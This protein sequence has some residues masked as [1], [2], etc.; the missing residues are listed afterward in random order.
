MWKSLSLLAFLA[1]LPTTGF[2]QTP[3]QPDF[4]KLTL[5]ELLDVN[6]TSVSRRDEPLGQTAAAITVIT[7]EDIRRTGVTSIPE[8]LRLVPGMQ[9]ARI[10][11]SSWAISA[12]GF[13][14][15]LSD[16]MLVLI[17]GR[18]VYSPIFAGVFWELQDLV[19][20]DVDR[21]EVVRGPGGTLWGANAVNGVVSI[22]TKSAHRTRSTTII[23]TG[24]GAES[25][26]SASFREGAAISPD[27]S[28][29]VYG[30]YSYR[31]QL[32][33]P[34]G[35]PSQDSA[36]FGRVGFRVDSS[37]GQNEFTLQADAFRGLE[38]L[39]G[40]PDAK[41]LGGDLLGRWSRRI[42]NDSSIQVKAS[43]DRLLRRALPNSDIH[44]KIFD[45]ELQ[46]DFA[47]GVHQITWGAGYRWNNDTAF[48]MPSLQFIPVSRTYP[49]GTAFIQ[50]EILL[51]QDRLRLQFGSKFEHNDFSGFEVQPSIRASWTIRPEAFMWVA[52]S[53]ALRTPTRFDT[54]SNIPEGAV[55]L[56]GNKDF[57]SEDVVA[58]ES[59]YRSQIA[60]RISADFAAFFN[61]YDDLRTIELV[62]GPR[63]AVSFL[64]NL[65]A[66]TYGGEVSVN[67]DAT[68]S[69]RFSS[70][71]AY[72]G[73][74]LR[75]D[76]GHID[77]AGNSLEGN[78]PKHQ[79]FIR[80]AVDIS[81]RIEWDSTLR[82]VSRLPSPATPKYFEFDARIGWN[83]MATVEL[84]AIGRNLLHKR[85]TEF[86]QT[87]TIQAQRDVYGRVAI[88]F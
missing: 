73:K 62:P 27:T 50:D 49:L 34:N 5:E 64:N 37:K 57:K 41:L 45:I 6:V 2:S 19:L 70:G 67:F 47:A 69:L 84:S 80:A 75:M 35:T 12:R 85:H 38:G 60:R 9:V 23:A 22:I 25:L 14:S 59:G 32:V 77:F 13:N 42:A 11:A 72:L 55:T 78:D 51:A 31:D 48:P 18:T 68:E 53:R 33:F 79:F 26:A 40:R 82:F 24:G 61:I 7:S 21:I 44:Q 39:P 4:K 83:P 46:H 74:R 30:K 88:R 8:A 17:D 36:R 81:Q 43:Y 10:G 66:K 56:F 63:T 16:K 20:D 86:A 71:Y 76:P 29:R 15:Q 87:T 52:V 65:N 1:V 3:S 54:D 58:F 28:Y